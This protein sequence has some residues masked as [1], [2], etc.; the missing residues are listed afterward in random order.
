M[1]ARKCDG[2]RMIPTSFGMKRLIRFVSNK[3]SDIP[4]DMFRHCLNVPSLLFLFLIS[5]KKK[6]T[7]WEVEGSS[8]MTG[9]WCGILGRLKFDGRS[10][11]SASRRFRRLLKF[12]CLGCRSKKS[13]IFGVKV[14]IEVIRY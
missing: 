8:L 5:Q 7:I 3:I 6:L 2:T 9:V 13:C 4:S 14:P 1:F 12:A 11:F 10:D